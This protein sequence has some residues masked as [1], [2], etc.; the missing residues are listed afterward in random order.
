MIVSALVW[1]LQDLMQVLAM[2]FMLVPEFFLMV[3]AYKIVSGPMWQ[4][5]IALWIWFSFFGGVLWDL[6]WGTS[7]GMSALINAS[8][9]T[10]LYAVWN[11]TPAGGRSAL[12][13][14]ALAGGIHVMSGITRYLAWAVPS[15]AAVRMFL[16]QQ[17][18]CIPVLAALCMMYAFK[19]PDAHV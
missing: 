19:R 3:V 10:L 17:L 7:P 12:L 2:G 4:T 5:R 8:A 13:F 14:A 9:V 15:H 18:L 6:R 1:L 16:I 11:R